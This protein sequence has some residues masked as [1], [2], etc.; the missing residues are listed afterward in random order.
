VKRRDAETFIAEERSGRNTVNGGRV[1]AGR[2]ERRLSR[3]KFIRGIIYIGTAFC[4]LFSRAGD[5]RNP[6]RGRETRVAYFLAREEH[7]LP[8]SRC[9]PSRS[10]L[11]N[12]SLL[13]YTPF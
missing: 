2:R 6:G 5:E 9:A 8:V 3:G 7:T 11:K 13:I 4:G 1:A 12:V 10:R